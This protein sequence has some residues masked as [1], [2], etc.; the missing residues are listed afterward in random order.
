MLALK[1]KP[2]CSLFLWCFRKAPRTSVRGSGGSF[3]SS[4]LFAVHRASEE[5]ALSRSSWHPKKTLVSCSRV[6]ASNYMPTCS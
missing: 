5:Q 2:Q 1:P 3:F 4:F 6:L